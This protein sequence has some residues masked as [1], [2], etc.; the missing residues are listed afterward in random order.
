MSEN[1]WKPTSRIHPPAD[2]LKPITGPSAWTREVLE[3][4]KSY[5]YRLSELEIGDIFDA[6]KKVESASPQLHEIGMEDFLLPVLGPVLKDLRE[7]VI[8]GR[9]FVFLRGL[10]TEGRSLFKTA[11][12][13]WGIGCH[14]GRAVSQNG[15]GHLLGHVKDLGAEITS[16]TGRGYNSA[17]PLG[18]HADSCDIFGL[19]VLKTSM[20]G[21]QHRMCSSVTVHNEML[22]RA[23]GL[24]EELAFRFYRSRRGELPPGETKPWTRQPIFS[25]TDGY[26]AAR[27]ASSTITRSQGMPGVPRLTESQKEAIKVY[28]EIATEIAMDV[29]FEPGD[30]SIVQ[31]Y[32]TLHSR[33]RYEDWPEPER[34]RHL[35]RLWL[36]FDGARPLHSDIVRDHAQG[37]QEEGTILHAPMDAA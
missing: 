22:K 11:A 10:P 15:K 36:S 27:G 14:F 2:L 28:N 9:G 33:T 17:S 7:E 26:F 18:F 6:V 13:F 30:I 19:C 21:G 8:K 25:V 34:K 35:L 5:L 12:A 23:P 4:N 32:V 1:P 37:I 29:D 3:E 24:V 20:S 31:N 16:P